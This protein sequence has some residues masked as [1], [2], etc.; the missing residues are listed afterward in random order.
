MEVSSGLFFSGD[1]SSV[2]L[3]VVIISSGLFVLVMEV[4]FCF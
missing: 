4:L 2:L 3:L 1:G